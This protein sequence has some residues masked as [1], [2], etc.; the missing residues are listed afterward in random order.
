MCGCKTVH[1][2]GCGC[3]GFI[4]SLILRGTASAGGGRRRYY[5]G[6]E[7]AHQAGRKRGQ[8]GDSE[9]QQV[10]AAVKAATNFA[11]AVVCRWLDR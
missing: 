6:I 3:R 1:V 7:A 11:P 8:A 2:I 9:L 5:E 10:V 4:V